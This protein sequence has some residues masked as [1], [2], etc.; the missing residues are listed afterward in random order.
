MINNNHLCS[1]TVQQSTRPDALFVHDVYGVH[2]FGHHRRA[3]DYFAA[4][5]TRNIFYNNI[6]TGTRQVFIDFFTYFFYTL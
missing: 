1:I 6:H 4:V 3:R 5:S 2:I